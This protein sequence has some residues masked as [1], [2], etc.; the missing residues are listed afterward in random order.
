MAVC[1]TEDQRRNVFTMKGRSDRR[2]V[3]LDFQL[4]MAVLLGKRLCLTECHPLERFDR[5]RRFE[6]ATNFA[7]T[8]SNGLNDVQR[9]ENDDD[10]RMVL[11]HVAQAL[12]EQSVQ[13]LKLL[14]DEQLQAPSRLSPGSTV[15]KHFRHVSWPNE[16]GLPQTQRRMTASGLFWL[17]DRFCSFRPSERRYSAQY[18]H[19]RKATR[20]SCPGADYDKRSRDVPMESSTSAAIQQLQELSTAIREVAPK[21]AMRKQ[22]DMEATTPTVVSLQSTFGREVSHRRSA[23]HF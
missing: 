3:Y 10:A 23:S 19:P 9:A 1:R 21:V 16:R 15:G 8:V 13:L 18:A 17:V 7:M 2:P 5:L 20:C 6:S 14:T 11:V 4:C 12:L 22:V